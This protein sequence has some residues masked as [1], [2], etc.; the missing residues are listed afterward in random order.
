M[1]PVTS[2]NVEFW[3]QITGPWLGYGNVNFGQTGL[4]NNSG[5]Y[6]PYTESVLSGHILW[7][8]D[9]HFGGV[10]G[11]DARGQD[12]GHY[13][14]TRQYQP[15]Y[16]PV[17]ING[18]MYSQ[19]YPES[20]N[21]PHGIL[22]TDLYTGETL[23]KINTTNALQCGMVMRYGAVNQYGAVGPFLWTTG[24]L[25]AA[26]TGGRQIGG[27]A[28][29]FM[30]TTGTQWN[31]YSAAD[32]QYILS[33]VNGTSPRF[34]VDANGNMIGYYINNTAGTERTYPTMSN[35]P[36]PVTSTGPHLTCFNMTRAIGQQ[37]GSWQPSLNTIRDAQTGVM[38]TVPVPTELAGKA[39]D[40]A[41]SIN[42]YSGDAV[43]M[44]G[45][46]IHG[47]GVGCEVP[48]WLVVASMDCATGSV[49]WVRNM[50]YPTDAWL[51]PFTR[52]SM[53]LGTGV[54]SMANDVNK[55]V[56]TYDART[57]NK[58]WETTLKT[59]YGDGKPN[60]YDLFSLKSWHGYNVMYWYGLGGDIWAFEPRTGEQKWYTNTTTL[61]GDPGTETPYG[62]WP[63]WVFNPMALT[64][65]VAYFIV[66]HEYNPPLFHGAQILAVNATNGELIWSEL[67]TYIRSTSVA[68]GRM[69]SLNAYDNR[70]YCFGKGPSATTVVAPSVGVTTASPITITGTVLDVSVGSLRHDVAANFPNG[71][72]CVSD[73]SQSK[74]MEYVYQ[75][76]PCPNDVAGVEVT[77]SVVDANGN[78]REIGTVT[79]NAMGSY[80]F[81]W[82]PDIPGDY[83]VV[84]N[85]AGSNSYYPSSAQTYFHATEFVVQPSPE[86]PQPIDNTMTVVYIGAAIMVLIA[87]VG[88][89]IVLMLRKR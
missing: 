5:P 67:G 43:I 64:K 56:V 69:L 30:N 88:A 68:Y 85:F 60:D 17:I 72:P 34:D 87:V 89:V 27:G 14:S 25:P 3:Y 47:Q 61:A 84:A 9:W 36:V 31:M 23:W 7:T 54:I 33:I 22:C 59:T 42:G 83:T 74:W 8:K 62:V 71:L 32:G 46:Y 41:L 6:N 75:Q 58:L 38:W 15:Q 57:G 18:Y 49:L 24:T 35:T 4:Y 79:T 44:T 82:T 73:A 48:G 12:A 65:D 70:I 40:P 50:T 63:L 86:Y 77:L 78:Y 21:L 80:G 26:D 2:Q 66:G 45:G 10:A 16:A 52:T 55:V 37:G 1:T 11:G 13:W 53:S 20:T 81:T 19:W 39:I 76:Q 51:L 29:D 28:S